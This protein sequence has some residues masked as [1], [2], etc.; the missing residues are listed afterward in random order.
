MKLLW[1]DGAD[2]P[3]IAAP[4]RFEPLLGDPHMANAIRPK[5][6]STAP[7]FT[8]DHTVYVGGCGVVT[9][10]AD[11]DGSV[12]RL[13]QLADGSRTPAE[14]HGI[15]AAD[16]PNVTASEVM[17]AIADLD[18][19]GFLEDAAVT[20]EGI[21]DDYSVRRWDRNLSFFEAYARLASD[22]YRLQ[23]RLQDLR[24]G[25]LGVGGLGSH[26]LYDLAAAGVQDIRIVDFDTVDLSNLN[27]QIIYNE[28]DIGRP[29]TEVASERIR[30]FS[31]RIQVEAVQTRITSGAEVHELVADRDLVVAVVDRP[32][33]SIAN[34]VNEG[35]VAAGVPF[36]AGG[37]ETKRAV[38]Y[39][40]VPGA[41]GCV[42]CWR[43]HVADT[44]PDA[45]AL[46]DEKRRLEFEGDNAAFGPLV[47]VLTG[48][49][50]A[51]VVRFATGIAAP[52]AV[53]RLMELKFDDFAIREAERWPRR[54]DCPLCSTAVAAAA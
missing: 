32:T 35:C 20:S 33:M 37:V 23:R 39:T 22:K 8:L 6:K 12:H 45:A 25:L 13:L 1:M 40:V 54:E 4:L 41:S 9:T 15:L 26:L 16:Y 18:A 44:D 53:G 19:A 29:K 49:M 31:P 36:I 7:V 51:E 11:P 34:W 48:C 47:T 43:A 2:A 24:V 50:L 10:I 21:L 28:A 42:A 14:I 5:V 3:S 17:D 38:Y 30:A 27:R 52:V 46:L